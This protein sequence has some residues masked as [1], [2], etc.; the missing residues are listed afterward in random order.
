MPDPPRPPRRS[1]PPGVGVVFAGWP[2]GPEENRAIRAGSQA[3]P[4]SHDRDAVFR[5]LSTP[6]CSR[7]RSVGRSACRRNVPSI[8]RRF[9][10]LDGCRSRTS[11]AVAG[12]RAPAGAGAR[13][14]E[15]RLLCVAGRSRRSGW[16]CGGRG[17]VRGARLEGRPGDSGFA[18]AAPR[19]PLVAAVLVGGVVSDRLPRCAVRRTDHTDA[20]RETRREVERLPDEQRLG[21]IPGSVEGAVGDSIVGIGGAVWPGY[22]LTH[23]LSTS[24]LVPRMARTR[25]ARS[26]CTQTR[27]GSSDWRRERTRAR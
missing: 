18:P 17:R 4:R 11:F 2:V 20:M 16:D 7:R 27:S 24:G 25:Y 13:E 6:A 8:L 21:R 5:S 23:R 15:S 9:A 10:Q 19:S 3:V 12:A 14:R 26:G 22:G 1:G